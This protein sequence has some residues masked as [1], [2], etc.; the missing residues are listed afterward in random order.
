[1]DLSIEINSLEEKLNRIYM[2]LLRLKRSANPNI[3]LIEQLEEQYESLSDI[4]F[5]L[6]DLNGVN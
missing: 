4:I 6:E 1:M 3:E 2:K 5:N